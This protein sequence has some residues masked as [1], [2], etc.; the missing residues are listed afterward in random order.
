VKFIFADSQD[1]IDPGYDF[2]TDSITPGRKPYWDDLYPHEVFKKPP[3]DGILVSRGIVGDATHHGKYSTPQSMRFKRVGAREF[4][5]YPESRFPGSLVFGDNG[6]FAYI[7]EA[8]PPISVDQTLEFYAEGRFTH[9]CSTDHV[10][11]HFNDD[12]L[13]N[14][15]P[16]DAIRFRYDITLENASEF[17]KKAPEL[18]K[19]FTPLGVVQGWSPQS[20]AMA[21]S[22]LLKMGYRY[23]AVGG[24]VPLK[25][26]QIHA[27][28]GHIQEVMKPYPEAR[29]HLLGFAK[30]DSIEEFV[31]YPIASFDST[32][33]LIRAFK[34]SSRNYYTSENS[35]LRY[36]SAIRIPQ[37]H[38][39]LKLRRL[40]R[41]GQVQLD[42][43]IK[44]EK[45]ALDAIRQVSEH[46]MDVEEAM[47]PII[48]YN[49]YLL[50]DMNETTQRDQLAL[51]EKRYR[52]TLISRPWEKCDCEI[53]KE[54]GVEVVIF[55]AS[56]RNRRRGFHNLNV[57]KEHVRSIQ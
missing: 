38:D 54:V 33:P 21:A 8:V 51:I 30:A 16:G 4:L 27:V 49:R 20:M 56:N 2:L 22:E 19:G 29:L 5:R 42:V 36:F 50:M 48:S 31:R 45:L 34:D 18:G 28:L 57:Y 6:A 10:I 43:L 40:V 12:L 46:T 44:A 55:R 53:C 3:Y 41:S 26:P 1:Q 25:A 23:L 37:V 15:D 52:D 17:F 35:R 32:S 39:N 13:A 24:L 14:I 7:K 47:Q 9:G 11:L